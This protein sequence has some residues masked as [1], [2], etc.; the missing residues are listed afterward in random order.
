[1]NTKGLN[2]VEGMLNYL[3]NKEI[4]GISKKV[5]MAMKVQLKSIRG[6]TKLPTEIKI[7][8]EE[9]KKYLEERMKREEYEWKIKRYVREAPEKVRTDRLYVGWF[10]K[11]K[12]VKYAVNF[13]NENFHCRMDKTV[14]AELAKQ[15]LVETLL[16]EKGFTTDIKFLS[17]NSYMKVLDNIVANIRNFHFNEVQI[18]KFIAEK[19]VEWGISESVVKCWLSVERKYNQYMINFSEKFWN[20]GELQ[21][22][23][24]KEYLNEIGVM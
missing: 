23:K 6:F 16:C 7:D 4:Q 17:R 13:I 5:T 22:E 2:E 8:K 14:A 15:Y 24:L 10:Y 3:L 1:M 12:N 18:E 9:F 11:E 19:M 21:E 20:N